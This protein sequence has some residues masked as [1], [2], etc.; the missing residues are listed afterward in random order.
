MGSMKER[1]AVTRARVVARLEREE[2]LIKGK[3]HGDAADE[4]KR[5]TDDQ[6]TGG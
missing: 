5:Q 4:K 2:K 6:I 3:Y 1:R